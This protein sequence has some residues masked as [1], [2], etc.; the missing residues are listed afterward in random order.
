MYEVEMKYM[1]NLRGNDSINFKC[2]NFDIGSSSYK[3]NNILMDNFK[4]V[5]LEVNN[6]DIASITIK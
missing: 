4:I 6:E 5:D 2:E 1:Q 3:F